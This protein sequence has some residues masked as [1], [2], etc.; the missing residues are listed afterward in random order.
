VKVVILGSG[1]AGAWRSEDGAGQFLNLGRVVETE[2]RSMVRRNECAREENELVAKG[3]TLPVLRQAR[4]N[5]T[6]LEAKRM[7]SR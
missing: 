2:D 1:E 3:E 6:R 7:T 5:A 4:W